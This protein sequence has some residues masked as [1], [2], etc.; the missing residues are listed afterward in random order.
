MASETQLPKHWRSKMHYQVL[1]LV[2]TIV[3]CIVL[4]KRWL[5]SPLSKY[6]GPFLASISRLWYTYINWRGTQHEVLQRLHVKYGDII[7][8]A[9]NEVCVHA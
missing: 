5:L 9:P 2:T 6:P 1:F 8:V 3:V 7:R 4:I